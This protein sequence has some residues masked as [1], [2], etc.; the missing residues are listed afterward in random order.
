MDKFQIE[1]SQNV[2][3]HQNVASI[4][5]R[6]LAFLLDTVV[7]ISYYI[8]IFW[9]LVS[10][11]LNPGDQWALFLLASLPGF[12]YYL[13][14]ETFTDGKTVGKFVV[15]TRVVKLDGSKPAFSNYF[16]RWILRVIE[17]T[18]T[19]GGGAVLTILLNG[20]GQRLGDIAAGTTVI[21]EKHLFKLSDTLHEEIPL[22]YQPRYPQVTLFTDLEIQEIKTMYESALKHGNHNVIVKLSHQIQKILEVKS[23]ET[24]L[25]FVKKIISDYNYYTQSM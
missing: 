11:D 19:S 10:L 15:K 16:L 5:D 18:L 7:I 25:E 12:L 24:P 17:V 22:D 9:I 14:L 6:M 4:I 2:G 13:I 21:S 23:S 20:K 3:I 8:L 1:T